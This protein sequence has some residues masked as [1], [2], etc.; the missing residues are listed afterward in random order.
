MYSTRARARCLAQPKRK[1]N[2][3]WPT[4]AVET[5][6]LA[7][8][9]VVSPTFFVVVA[10]ALLAISQSICCLSR[11]H[12]SLYTYCIAQVRFMTSTAQRLAMKNLPPP[13]SPPSGGEGI[14]VM[15][16]E[17]LSSRLYFKEEV[18]IEVLTS[19]CCDLCPFS[20][21]WVR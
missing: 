3:P 14:R 18:V 9:D 21:D 17:D 7:S 5:S 12:T 10:V 20:L 13:P 1:S 2:Q 4:R 16:D 8:V 11:F 15:Y 19:L 6:P